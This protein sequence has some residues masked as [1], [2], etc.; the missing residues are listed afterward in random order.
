GPDEHHAAGDEHRKAGANKRVEAGPLEVFKAKTLFSDAALLEE[1]LPRSDGRA[2]DSDDQ[3]DQISRDLAAAEGRNKCARGGFVP[4]R[5]KQRGADEPCEVEQAQH[6]DDALP[7]AIASGGD[8]ADE[9][10]R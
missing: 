4:H 7:A 10:D 6:D 9:R 1:E 5:V 8:K 2:D 3:E